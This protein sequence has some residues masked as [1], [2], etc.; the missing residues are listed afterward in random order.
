MPALAASGSDVTISSASWSGS[1]YSVSGITFPLTIAAGKS[2]S[3]TVTFSPQ[4]G[5]TSSGSISFVSNAGNSPTQVTLNGA[6]MHSVSLAWNAGPSTV[7][8]YNVYRGSQSGGPY[9][10]INT[11]LDAATSYTDTNVQAGTT[12]FYVVTAVD[13]SGKE[14]AF[15]NQSAATIPSP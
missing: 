5:G 2:V 12:N 4:S 7:A 8:G 6:G 11:S 1:G 9:T 15:S 14:S 13:A 3:F 10:R